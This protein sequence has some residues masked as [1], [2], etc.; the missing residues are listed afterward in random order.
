[1]T[2]HNKHAPQK[3]PHVPAALARSNN[4]MI[5]AQLTFIISDLL[6]SISVNLMSHSA[7]EAGF[8]NHNSG[9]RKKVW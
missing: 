5:G 6:L 9:L 3:N 1:M 7:A 2:V 4:G 8:M